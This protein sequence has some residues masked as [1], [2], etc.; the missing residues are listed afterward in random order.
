MGHVVCFVTASSEREAR[1]IGDAVVHERLAACANVVG[2]IS[3]T[4]WWRGKVESAEEVLLVLKTR[5]DLVPAL[6]ALVRS[7]HSYEVPEVIALR[8][9]GGNAAY[10]RWIDESVKR[11]RARPRRRRRPSA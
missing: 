4:Y 6:T 3:S 10:L 9:T 7:L 11:P 5:A 2:P 1:A 8:I